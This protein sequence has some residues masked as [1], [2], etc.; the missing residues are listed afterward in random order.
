MLVSFKVPEI[1]DKIYQQLGSIYQYQDRQIMMWVL[2]QLAHTYMAEVCSALL[3]CPLPI[4]RYIVQKDLTT[5]SLSLS[6]LPLPQAASAFSKLL[7]MPKSSEVALYIY[8]RLLMALLVQ[9]H[10]SIRHSVIKNSDSQEEFEPV[11][12]IVAAL[13]IL[14]LAVRCY[15][16][17]TLIEKERGWELLTSCEDHHRGVGLIARI[18]LQT[19]NYDLLRILYL[20]VPF[21]ERGDEEHQITG[22]A[23][24]SELLCMSEARRLP[25]QYSLYRLKRGLA[26]E[27]PVIRALCI[28]GLVNIA[29]WIGKVNNRAHHMISLDLVDKFKNISDCICDISLSLQELFSDVRKQCHTSLVLLQA[30][31]QAYPLTE[32]LFS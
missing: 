10:Y 15:C 31:R 22:L 12:Y 16:E 24:F 20:L 28:K 17:F 23:F 7:S 4:D 18:M 25:K 8:P 26:N 1:V 2:A 30:K 6:L 19:S 29:Y 14:L 3:Q 13:K 5:V 32:V 27:N 11:G 9:V 21:L